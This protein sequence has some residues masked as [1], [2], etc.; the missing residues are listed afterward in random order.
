MDHI[1]LLRLRCRTFTL[2]KGAAQPVVIALEVLLTFMGKLRASLKSIFWENVISTV[3][4]CVCVCVCVCAVSY[5]HLRAH[6]TASY[7]V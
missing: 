2:S 1:P 5:K 3:V 7:R 6:E 4:W